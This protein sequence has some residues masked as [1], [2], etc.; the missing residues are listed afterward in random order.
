MV[1]D[2]YSENDHRTKFVLFGP[3]K[4]GDNLVQI[5]DARVATGIVIIN[6]KVAV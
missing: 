3:R 1:T 6:R 4:Y 5:I 2:K